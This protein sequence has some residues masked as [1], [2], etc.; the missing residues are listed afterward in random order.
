MHWSG[1]CTTRQ[2]LPQP[3]PEVLNIGSCG[4]RFARLVG[5]VTHRGSG[6]VST[7]PARRGGKQGRKWK[8]NRDAASIGEG[9]SGA[10]SIVGDPPSFHP[11]AD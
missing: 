5:K 10:A 6:Q 8:G 3:S 9:N 7:N 2:D 4:S 1:I 11:N